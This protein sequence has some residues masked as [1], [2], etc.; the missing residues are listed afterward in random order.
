MVRAWRLRRAAG[1]YYCETC[2][3]PILQGERHWVYGNQTAAHR[4]CCD[5]VSPGAMAI[6]AAADTAAI[7]DFGERLYAKTQD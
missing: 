2:S 5:C 1:D 7:V 6:F 4:Y 3:W